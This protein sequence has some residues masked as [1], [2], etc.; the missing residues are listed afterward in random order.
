MDSS[1]TQG[2]SRASMIILATVVFPEALPPPRP[3]GS[4]GGGGARRALPTKSPPRKPALC[5]WRAP[6][7][8]M[9]GPAHPPGGG[10]GGGSRLTDGKGLLGLCAV[11][12]VPGRPPRCVN[13]AFAGAQQGRL[14]LALAGGALPRRAPSAHGRE[15]PV[16]GLGIAA[17]GRRTARRPAHRHA[18]RHIRPSVAVSMTS[19]PCGH[20]GMAE[21]AHKTHLPPTHSHCSHKFRG[22]AN[23]NENAGGVPSMPRTVTWMDVGGRL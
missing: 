10:Q 14:G 6:W 4:G 11:L 2:T 9:A 19:S 3:A 17:A 23:R 8:L 22:T 1:T 20:A 16:Q 18:R 12:V 7:H 15:E 5:R 21:M 13:G